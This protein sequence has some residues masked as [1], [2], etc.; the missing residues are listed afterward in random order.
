MTRSVISFKGQVATNTRD[1]NL[2]RC[3]PKAALDTNYQYLPTGLY[4]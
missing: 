1:L 4:R 2:N 3:V